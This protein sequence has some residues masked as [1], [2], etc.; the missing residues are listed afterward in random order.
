MPE[1]EDPTIFIA[2]QSSNQWDADSNV[3]T[4]RYW[5]CTRTV[6]FFSEF[7]STISD[8][9]IFL[10]CSIAIMAFFNFIANIKDHMA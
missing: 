6:Q 3:Y 1:I 5:D 7:V 2:G 8:F 9:F 10:L 4:L